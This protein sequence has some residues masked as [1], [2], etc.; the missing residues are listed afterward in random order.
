MYRASMAEQ[1]VVLAAIAV[2]ALVV[3]AYIARYSGAARGRSESFYTS[4]A[5]EEPTRSYTPYTGTIP[6][7]PWGT[8][9]WAEATAYP[10][11]S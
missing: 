8:L 10:G 9:P 6:Y 3:I 11:P 4:A 1:T 2:A 7:G 5:R